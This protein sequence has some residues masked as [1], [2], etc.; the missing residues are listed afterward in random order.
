MYSLALVFLCVSAALFAS[1]QA[2]SASN[3]LATLLAQKSIAALT[4]GVV[5]SSGKFFFT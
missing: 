4:G 2:K 5:A 1:A 3:P